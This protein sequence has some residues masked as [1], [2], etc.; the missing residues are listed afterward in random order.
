MDDLLNILGIVQSNVVGNA[1]EDLYFYD[2][3]IGSQEDMTPGLVDVCIQWHWIFTPSYYSLYSLGEHSC[4]RLRAT[5]WW[6][7]I[8]SMHHLIFIKLTMLPGR[9]FS[10]YSNWP[11]KHPTWTSQDYLVGMKLTMINIFDLLH[12]C[13]QG[14]VMLMTWCIFSTW[15]S[16]SYSVTWWIF[17]VRNKVNEGK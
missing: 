7:R 3:Q 2:W 16:P 13:F 12:I 14:L 6:K 5:R 1:L 11:F 17:W 8:Q 4:L 9:A 10:I 15:I